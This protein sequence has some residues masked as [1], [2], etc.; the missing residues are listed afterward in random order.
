ML[1]RLALL[2]IPF[3]W[4]CK[5]DVQYHAKASPA[6]D[7]GPSRHAS[8]PKHGA[9]ARNDG[10]EEAQMEAIFHLSLEKDRF[11]DLATC[12]IACTSTGQC[13]KVRSGWFCFRVCKSDR[14]CPDGRACLCSSRECRIHIYDVFPNSDVRVCVNKSPPGGIDSPEVQ[15]AINEQ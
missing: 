4:G 2:A 12:R 14:E 7:D 1:A 10:N 3:A 9:S 13:E 11:V 5:N 6:N 8:P 15:R